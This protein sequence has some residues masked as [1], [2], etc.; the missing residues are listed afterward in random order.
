MKKN[1]FKSKLK[2]LQH[3]VT[4]EEKRA[5]LSS[6]NS[7]TTDRNPSSRVQS[8]FTRDPS[9]LGSARIDTSRPLTSVGD[10]NAVKIATSL[11]H[12][13]PYS[14]PTTAKPLPVQIS[15]HCNVLMS[16]LNN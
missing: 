13:I 9:S 3:E 12:I 5:R 8:A 1:D 2:K 4:T 15:S 16:L 11:G 7:L 10:Q 6:K 14:A